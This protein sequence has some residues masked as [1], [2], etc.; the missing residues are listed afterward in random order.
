MLLI[1]YIKSKY[2]TYA[3]NSI[4][5]VDLILCFL[6]LRFAFATLRRRRRF[7]RVVY[8]LLRLY[9]FSFHLLILYL[10]IRFTKRLLQPKLATTDTHT[11][12][13]HTK[14]QWRTNPTHSIDYYP[15]EK[16]CCPALYC[17]WLLTRRFSS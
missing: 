5:W 3:R 11:Q 6:L 15:I 9:P 8:F 14:L 12:S 2:I 16:L 17:E 7:A 1:N 10:F 13:I 4:A